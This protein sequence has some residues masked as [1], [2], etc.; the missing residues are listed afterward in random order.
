MWHAH[1]TSSAIPRAQ[2]AANW[3]GAACPTARQVVHRSA[4]GRARSLRSLSP[5]AARIAPRR[6]DDPLC[7]RFVNNGPRARFRIARLRVCMR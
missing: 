2:H 5:P 6:T 1:V 3:R 7:S 4:R